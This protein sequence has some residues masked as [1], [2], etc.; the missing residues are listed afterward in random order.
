MIGLLVQESNSKSCG[1]YV[2]TRG[3][4]GFV[5]VTGPQFEFQ[6]VC[7]ACYEGSNK[8]CGGN[9]Y[10][11]GGGGFASR[12]GEKAQ[13]VVLLVSLVPQLEFQCICYEGNGKSC[14][15]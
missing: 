12:G 5:S 15:E 10:M 13:K 2:Y 7:K 6:C 8:S 4:G 9:A 11:R 14:G 1:D 3:G